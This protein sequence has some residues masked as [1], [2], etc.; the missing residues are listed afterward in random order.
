MTTIASQQERHKRHGGGAYI[1]LLECML[2]SGTVFR[3][4]NNTEDIEWPTGSGTAWQHVGFGLDDVEDTDSGELRE[5]GIKVS[6][7]SAAL[8]TYF[9]ELEVWRKANGRE[10]CQ[11]RIIVVNSNLLSQA[12][13]EKEWEFEDRGMSH[14]MKQASIRLAV[15]NVFSRQIPRRT[16]LRDFCMWIS[17]DQCPHVGICDRTLATCRATYDNA[18]NFGGFPM[19]EKGALYSA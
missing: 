18:I 1:I 4:A 2:P 3:I 5:T 11:I 19:C 7:P 12:D 10:R 16:I 15:A 13:P 14:D 8:L 9:K 6:D 17:T